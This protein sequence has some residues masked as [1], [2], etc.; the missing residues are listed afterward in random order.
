MLIKINDEEFEVD[1]KV[2]SHIETL[3]ERIRSQR[4]NEGKEF[5]DRVQ[6]MKIDDSIDLNLSLY[7]AKKK[8]LENKKF[9]IADNT[10]EKV[11]DGMIAVLA[12]TPSKK[13]KIADNFNDNSSNFNSSNDWNELKK[14]MG[15]N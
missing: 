7:D 1:N 10:D 4:E 6:L 9:K 12:Q 5:K 15:A 2:V 14:I 3:Q 13:I 11:L 8:V